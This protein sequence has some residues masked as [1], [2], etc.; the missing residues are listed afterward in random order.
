VWAPRPSE[1]SA[2][3]F[4]QRGHSQS[5]VRTRWG[6]VKKSYRWEEIDALIQVSQA[7]REWLSLRP[8]SGD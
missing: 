3:N 7:E 8:G 6:R 1:S 2:R 5:P 4:P